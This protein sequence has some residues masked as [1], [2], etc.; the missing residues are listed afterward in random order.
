MNES[1]DSRT[2]K[3]LWQSQPAEA[4]RISIEYV[5]YHAEKLNADLHKQRIMSIA[6]GAVAAA[7]CIV[8]LL[9]P[10]TSIPGPLERVNAVAA[11]FLVGAG[12]YISMQWRR[13]S[14]ALRFQTGEGVATG[15]DAYRNELKRRRDL[16][17]GSWR[18]SLWPLLPT[19]AVLF[20]GGALYDPRPHKVL[21]YSIGAI[22]VI[23]CAWVVRRMNRSKAHEFQRELD[24]L[25]SLYKA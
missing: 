13:R 3:S 5:R 19:T 24:A 9:V 14:Q 8:Y 6:A 25:G 10:D 4:P 18:W 21:R 16:Y 22:V 15:L 20:I 17:L 7:L 2:G 1:H 23:A 12:L 11:A